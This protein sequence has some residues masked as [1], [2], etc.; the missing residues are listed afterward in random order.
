MRQRFRRPATPFVISLALHAVLGAG[1]LR[2]LLVPGPLRWRTDAPPK[3]ERVE[4]VVRPPAGPVERGRDGGDDRPR[5]KSPRPASRPL[6][7]PVGVPTVMPTPAATAPAEAGGSGERIG[8]GGPLAGIRP[9]YNDPRVWAP[10][11]DEVATLPMTAAERLDRTL[12]D[13]IARHNDSLA[14]YTYQPNR[15]E[16]GDWTVNGPGGKWGVDSTRIRLGK[17]SLPSAVLA[18]LPLNMQGGSRAAGGRD[19]VRERAFAAIRA[20]INY[21]SQRMLNE[22]ELR[23]A[24]KR[25]RERVDRERRETAARQQ[26]QPSAPDRTLQP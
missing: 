20:D 23:V 5:T 21:Q 9:S 7:A 16:R 18:M 25:I 17:F 4:F 19:L 22:E 13:D 8:T 11:S 26:P 6:V 24:A 1:L 2:V 14:L 12:K 15:L 10:P 3:A